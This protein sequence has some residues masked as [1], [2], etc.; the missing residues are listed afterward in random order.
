M[1][2]HLADD[3]AESLRDRGLASNA[4]I[5]VLREHPVEHRV[6][7]LVADLVR[8]PF[9]YRFG[10]QKVRAGG[11]EGTSHNDGQSYPQPPGRQ[12]DDLCP[13]VVPAVLWVLAEKL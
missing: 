2:G 6:R 11:T 12:R 10:G 3:D 9:G 8:M 4:S 13:V 5:R 1:R 7:D